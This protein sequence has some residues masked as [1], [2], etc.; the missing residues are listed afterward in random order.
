MQKGPGREDRAVRYC[1]TSVRY[2]GRVLSKSFGLFSFCRRA[3]HD[4]SP[5]RV[6]VVYSPMNLL[7]LHL[8]PSSAL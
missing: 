7:R 4:P 5:S 3:Q 1:S 6:A 2:T 8:W